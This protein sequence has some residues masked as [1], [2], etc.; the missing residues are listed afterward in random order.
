MFVFGSLTSEEGADVSHRDS[1]V[2]FF[3]VSSFIE[4]GQTS[5]LCIQTTFYIKWKNLSCKTLSG[6]Y[7]GGS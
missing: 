2:V 7:R 1:K 3:K 6:T 4:H 5:W